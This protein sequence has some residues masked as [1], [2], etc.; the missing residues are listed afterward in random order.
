[1][2]K[3]ILVSV[4]IPVYNSEKHISECIDS[5]LHQTVKNI[6][7]IIINDGSTDN[8]LNI[9]NNYKNGYPEIFNVIDERNCGAPAARNKGIRVAKGRYISFIDAD[10]YIAP[11]MIEKLLED[12]NKYNSDITICNHFCVYDKGNIIKQPESGYGIWKFD[13]REKINIYQRKFLCKGINE[14]KPYLLMGYPWGRLFKR[15]LLVENNIL[16]DEELHRSEDGIFN[17]LAAQFSKCIIF[18]DHAYYYYRISDNS[19]S[20]KYYPNII[21][22][23]ERDVQDIIKIANQY[24]KNDQIFQQGINVRITMW[25]HS[26]LD[27]F[28]FHPE[29]ISKYGY[30][31]AKKEIIKVLNREPYSTAFNKVNFKL[32]TKKERIFVLLLKFHALDC[33]YIYSKIRKAVLKL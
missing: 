24:K 11:E 20:R 2:N 32:M 17:I 27:Y 28:F 4:I 9:C 14:Y 26:Y 10:D 21:K 25:F 1:M 16:F 5:I 15:N 3:D 12:A 33:I 19:L 18:D 6:E 23:C 31:H 7:I 30:F 13:T 22:N 8:S 29:Y